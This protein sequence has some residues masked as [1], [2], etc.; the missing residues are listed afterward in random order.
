MSC[1]VLISVYQKDNHVHFDKAI[2]SIVDQSLPPDEIVLVKDGPLTE[3][4]E[5]V[6]KKWNQQFPGFF[7]I[8]SL[9]HNLGLGAALKVG[10]DACTNELVARMDADDISM[11]ERLETQINHFNMHPEISILGS[12]AI[13]IDEKG[14]Q[15]GYRK[16]PFKHEEIRKVLPWANPIIHASVMFRRDKIL[17]V[18]SYSERLQN[19]QDY[20]L[21]FR[22]MASNLCFANLEKPLI[23]YRMGSNY[24]KRKSWKYRLVDSKVRW[25]SYKNLN[26]KFYNRIAIFV[27]IMLGLVPSSFAP[28]FYEIAK[29]LDPRQRNQ[30]S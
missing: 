17:K 23:L 28:L 19:L 18:G 8:I 21:W 11:P 2:E 9:D 7:K 10:L 6:I 30:Y 26:I 15:K 16:V 27:P 12:S 13:D 3:T 25:N 24:H 22:C 14:N 20:D 4:L 29:K 1:S 5:E